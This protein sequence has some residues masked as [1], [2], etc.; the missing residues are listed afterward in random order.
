[1][2]ERTEEQKLNIW[3][4]KNKFSYDEAKKILKSVRDTKSREYSTYKHSF[5]GRHIKI[6]VVGD[7]HFGNKWTDKRFL[8]DIMDFF[9][10]EQV[11]AVYHLGDMVDGPWQ[12]HKNVLE[13]YAHGFDAQIDDFVNDFP[14]IGIHTYLITGNHGMWFMKGEGANVGRAIDER[15]D[16][17]TFLG[18][19][20]AVVKFGKLE[21]LLSHPD[22][23]GSAYAYSYK[24]QKFMEAMFKQGEKVP[25]IILQGHYHKL[26]HMSFGGTNYYCTGTTERQ[27]PFMRS[28]NVAADLGA[29]VLDIYRDGKGNL[30]RVDDTLL[31]YIGNKHKQAIK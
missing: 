15:R 26:F 8:R 9:K 31:P 28:Q 25:D 21:M 20:E 27:T 24:P 1:M 16:D 5:S 17:I 18:D 19:N 7:T 13:Q 11:S 30:I 14:D 29:W 12:R 4:K 3:L 2:V 23:G 10:K 6:G 22:R